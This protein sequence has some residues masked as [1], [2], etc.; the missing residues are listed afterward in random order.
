MTTNKVEV[1]KQEWIISY[2]S[3][4][5]GEKVKRPYNPHSE[6]Q[7]EFI[8][9]STGKLCKRYFDAVKGGTRTANAPWTIKVKKKKKSV[10]YLPVRKINK[11]TSRKRTCII[12]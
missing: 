5:D 1:S 6:M 9:K 7:Y 12:N 2:Y 3:K 11:K 4:S 10:T 8:A